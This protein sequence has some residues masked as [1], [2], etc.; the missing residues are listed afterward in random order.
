[1][2]AVTAQSLTA[3]SQPP[4]VRPGQILPGARVTCL[5][6]ALPAAEGAMRRAAV[7][8]VGPKFTRVRLLGEDRDRRVD[9][10][11]L[12]LDN[13]AGY[14]QAYGLHERDRP[15][16]HDSYTYSRCF[17][18]QRWKPRFAWMAWTVAEH[19]EYAAGERA[20][21]V[22]SL[23]GPPNRL[24][25]V[26]C[27]STKNAVARQGDAH[28]MYLGSYHRAAR[29]AADAL[30]ARSP[31]RWGIGDGIDTYQM[32]LSAQYGLLDLFTVIETYDLRMG[33]PGSVSAA[34]V[35]Y[36]AQQF[37]LAD[38]PEV[39]VLAGRAYADAVSEVWPH[40]IRPLDGTRGIGEQLAVM[41]EIAHT[42]QLPKPKEAAV[43]TAPA[44]TSA[45]AI[46]AHPLAMRA[47]AQLRAGDVFVHSE[48][49][50]LTFVS[51][52]VASSSRPTVARI[53]VA[54]GGPVAIDAFDGSRVEIVSQ[55]SVDPL[56]AHVRKGSAHLF[57]PLTDDR[58][59]CGE[60]GDT[61]TANHIPT[62]GGPGDDTP[63]DV[64]PLLNA[65]PQPD[66]AARLDEMADVFAALLAPQASAPDPAT[67]LPVIYPGDVMF[68]SKEHP[69]GAVESRVDELQGHEIIA[70]DGVDIPGLRLTTKPQGVPDTWADEHYR[71]Y[72]VTG[73]RDGEREE[74]RV[75]G[76][77]RVTV[78]PD[79]MRGWTPGHFQIGT[80]TK[81]FTVNNPG[82]VA[83]REVRWGGLVVD[84]GRLVAYSDITGREQHG[85]GMDTPFEG[86]IHRTQRDG[87]HHGWRADPHVFAPTFV[88][89]VRCRVC[90]MHIGNP[91]HTGILNA[92]ATL[93]ML[94][95]DIV[96][97]GQTNCGRQ[98]AAQEADRYARGIPYIRY[99]RSLDMRYTFVC[100]IPHCG[101]LRI[102]WSTRRGLRAAWFAHAVQH[103]QW[104]AAWPD[105]QWPV[106]PDVAFVV[107]AAPSAPVRYA[108]VEVEP[109][110]D[111]PWWAALLQRFTDEGRTIVER[112]GSVVIGFTEGSTAARALKK[113]LVAAG[114]R[115]TGVKVAVS[116]R[117]ATTPVDMAEDPLDLDAFTRAM[118]QFAQDAATD[119]K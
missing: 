5:P 92:D 67:A 9:N 58:R 41:S 7:V 42:G 79:A 76:S 44:R 104:R 70:C 87:D 91:R 21:P 84:G 69:A 33:R 103:D 52:T 46:Q 39:I 102:G 31:G 20:L 64:G 16:P 2:R 110:K 50:R 93:A 29:R 109:A 66:Q 96:R 43:S 95:K 40:A 117:S 81:V 38:T 75:W 54:E 27:S 80:R 107:P 3:R 11:L 57:V 119:A 83:L 14:P 105:D 6:G 47:P 51:S 15:L 71:S 63:I 86:A 74:H 100:P 108:E 8:S 111:D 89:S 60:C 35:A 32:I 62:I 26:G 99:E 85:I 55:G 113:V 90:L 82:G 22:L 65:E 78:I 115:A 36:Q 73:T 48:R 49:G 19:L 114:F 72:L 106:E 98:H 68:R 25:I 10:T 112:R 23:F 1:M 24:V 34:T 88:G 77:T 18:I 94:L 61:N 59:R 45:A 17:G 56:F 116:S 13:G 4:V 101:G 12:I 28:A 30:V 118:E 37:G 97:P 53:T